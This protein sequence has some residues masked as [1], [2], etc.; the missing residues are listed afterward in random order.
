MCRMPE[1][2]QQYLQSCV[3]V[4]LCSD[5]LDGW[6]TMT[7]LYLTELGG[8]TASEGTPMPAGLSLSP[9]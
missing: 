7:T 3:D 8:G 5:F 9:F 4:M 1:V 6:S 2:R